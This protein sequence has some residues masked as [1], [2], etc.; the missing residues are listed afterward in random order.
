MRMRRILNQVRAV[1]TDH[2]SQLGKSQAMM[3]TSSQWALK[4]RPRKSSP[5]K[6]R[7]FAVAISFLLL[8]LASYGQD[9]VGQVTTYSALTSRNTSAALAPNVQTVTGAP[10]ENVSKIPITS[11]LPSASSTRVLVHL[12]VWFGSATHE[13]VG[14]S[15][16]NANQVQQQVA[17]IL[18]RG[19]SGVIVNWHGP[20][21]FTDQAAQLVMQQAAETPSGT[22]EFALEEDAQALAQC[23]ATANCDIA[24]K[25]VSDLTYLQSTYA[26][27]SE[28][29]KYQGRPVI[30]LYGM[31]AY[32]L[33][34]SKIQVSLSDNPVLVFR[35]AT[36]ATAA[37]LTPSAL[38][39][40]S[41][42]SN[43]A[44][45]NKLSTWRWN[46]A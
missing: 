10:S 28:Y 32:Q 2:P 11:L 44:Q 19:V 30:F 25:V 31:E 3:K 27:A 14:Y 1:H 41:I 4:L 38:A 9:S 40:A 23:A 7:F 46:R 45:A 12:D 33:G 39:G 29:M 22:F 43:W 6:L 15:S 5:T 35:S 20:S 13:N 34:W 18:S 16:T 24:G 17:D 42:C 36:A 8:T 37:N 26:N 21:D